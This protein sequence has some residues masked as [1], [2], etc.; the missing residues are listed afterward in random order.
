LVDWKF[1]L[2][3]NLSLDPA[4]VARLKKQYVGLWY[5]RYIEGLW[6]LAEGA[7]YGGLIDESNHVLAAQVPFINKYF[8]GV[9][10]ATSAATAYVMIGLG[11]D[12]CLYVLDEYY[13]SGDETKRDKAPS[14][15]AQEYIKWQGDRQVSRV[16]IDPA[17]KAFAV[18]L[19][20]VIQ[21]SI[22]KGFE[23]DVNFGI[24]CVST[25]I[26]NNRIK[27]VVKNLPRLMGELSNYV[28]DE[29]Y[30]LLG[31]DKPVKKEDHC[32]DALRY[33]I[34]G[35]RPIWRNWLPNNKVLVPDNHLMVA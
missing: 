25:L 35:L 7:V 32:L 22:K 10:F 24:G 13:W 15:L 6:A 31:K 28:W 19:S 23:R 20:R 29:K 8:V 14:E 26:G 11:I 4:Y 34:V 1:T 18:E 16:Y 17:A 12:N 9:D 27:F 5:K 33:A 21:P 3:D 30:S 2:D